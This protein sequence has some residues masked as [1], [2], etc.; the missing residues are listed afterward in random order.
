VDKIELTCK[1]R[2]VLGKKVRFLRREGITPV[3]LFG[4][5]ID[6]QALQCGT[7][8]LKQTLY[9][10][11]MT[12]LVSLKVDRARA[13]RNVMVREAQREPRSGDLL[14]VDFYQ[15]SMEEKIRVDVPIVVTGESPALRSKDAL[16]S[17]ELSTL[18][19]ECL[20][21]E[22]PNEV[23]IDIST[24]E[25]VD[26]AI[27]VSDVKL[28]GEINILNNP[29][30]LVLKISA[31]RV[32]VEEVVPEEEEIPEEERAEAEAAAPEGAAP[33]AEAKERESA[34]D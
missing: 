34:S 30:Q 20:P 25:E 32:G 33:A 27:H 16:L 1:S 10:A 28:D 7:S 8:E 17:Q 21:D 14:H 6:S 24:L 31:Q 3:H 9:Q 5:S 26:D 12:R 19:V 2:E 4:H 18:T 13:P 23:P 15:V 22:I 29:E 11:G